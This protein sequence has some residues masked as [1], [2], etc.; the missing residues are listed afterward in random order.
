MTNLS[1]DLQHKHLL[2]SDR[3]PIIPQ[4]GYCQSSTWWT[5]E[6]CWG[7]FQ[8]YGWTVT[9]RRKDPKT[10]TSIGFTLAWW[11]LTKPGKSEE[12][13][14]ACRQLSTLDSVLSKWLWFSCLSG[15]SADF[16]SSRKLVSS[17]LWLL[18]LSSGVGG[19]CLENLVSFKDFLQVFWV[20][21]LPA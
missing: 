9:Y 8:E 20:V 16:P 7:C 18:T 11:L 14:A 21:Y 2:T 12:C 15:S 3:D 5:S 10:T 4:H 17:Q 6:H 1:W 13:W 19:C